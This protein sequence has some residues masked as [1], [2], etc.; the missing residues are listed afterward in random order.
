MK[1]AVV[2]AGIFG[3]TISIKLERAG[4]DVD[5][6][7]KNE[8]ILMAASG[9]NQFR[10]HRGYHYPRSEETVLECLSSEA[11]FRKEYRE[12]V[13]DDGQKYYCIA[14]E[15]SLV[16]AERYLSFCR[17]HN[18]GFKEVSPPFI[19]RAETSLCI[20]V[21][22][23]RIDF[24][25]LKSICQARLVSAGVSLKLKNPATPKILEDYDFV[26]LANYADSNR[27]SHALTEKRQPLQFEVCE[28]PVILMPD[29]FSRI[30]VVVMDGPFMCVD[31]Y[32]YK[33]I[34]LMGNVV[35]AIHQSN[36]GYEPEIR[37][38]L[39]D[40]LNKG[41][42]FKPRPTNF[43]KFIESG[44]AFLPVLKKAVHLGSMFTVRAVLP[45]VESSD[46]R[47]TIVTRLDERVVSVFSGKIGTCVSAAN[48]V[49]EIIKKVPRTH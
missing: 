35:W 14:R 36:V 44:S 29:V 37:P 24:L 4:I 15:K 8:D 27:L 11:E 12:A 28:K 22:E 6:F 2:G 48:Q 42:I 30:S 39:K 13:V 40:L 9:I 25:A 19:N 1:V 46:A 18:L 3:I 26:V 33:S 16:S 32:R 7:E 17:E 23:G 20:K 43:A 10:L 41:I 31:P 45:G 34:F 21:P 47:P 5:L 38:E 49:L